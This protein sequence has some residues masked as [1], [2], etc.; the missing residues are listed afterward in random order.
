M[1]YARF[2]FIYLIIKE[3]QNFT[4]TTQ[5]QGDKSEFIRPVFKLHS[6]LERLFPMINWDTDILTLY[7]KGKLKTD[8]V[9]N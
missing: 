5:L 9:S 6:K 1:I 8:R 3:N 4:F 7:K 2:D